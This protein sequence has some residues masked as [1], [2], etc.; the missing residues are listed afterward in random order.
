MV[1]KLKKIKVFKVINT[2]LL[3]IAFAVSVISCEETPEVVEEQ[4]EEEQVEVAIPP[5]TTETIPETTQQLIEYKGTVFPLPEFS[6]FNPQTGELLALDGNPWGVEAN[7][8]IGELI[9]DANA[10]INGKIEN[11]FFGLIPDG[12][13]ES[14]S[15]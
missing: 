8:K 11:F 13:F 12:H 14:V 1:L 3:V 6:E 4:Q 7:T 15:K 9:A 5:E 2:T 10:E